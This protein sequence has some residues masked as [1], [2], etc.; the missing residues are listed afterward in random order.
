[1]QTLPKALQV[2]G[3][4]PLDLTSSPCGV[5]RLLLHCAP[6]PHPIPAALP[7][8]AFYTLP[9]ALHQPHQQDLVLLLHLMHSIRPGFPAK[10]SS[11]LDQVKLTIYHTLPAPRTT[12]LSAS[13]ASLST[14]TE[15]GKL[16]RSCSSLVSDTLGM[17]STTHPAA[18]TLAALVA[19]RPARLVPAPGHL[20]WLFLFSQNSLT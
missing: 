10:I 9:H 7:L 6:S 15:E 14:A 3:K 18:V 16:D 19:L 20:H 4:A 12:S 17:K 2:R 5:R 13:I 11:L 8:P 1:M